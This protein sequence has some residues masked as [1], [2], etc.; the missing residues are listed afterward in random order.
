MS[1][2]FC[3][4]GAGVIDCP[5]GHVSQ[6]GKLVYGRRFQVPF[7]D[8]I[9]REVGISTIAVGNIFEVDHVNIII[10]AGRANLCDI[11]RLNVPATAWKQPSKGIPTRGGPSSI[12]VAS[13]NSSAI[14][15][16]RTFHCTHERETPNTSS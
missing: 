5:T 4:A 6:A 1:R 14:A 12:S 15:P 3:T 16:G 10:A 13:C 7:S 9:R 2:L 11:A 8:C